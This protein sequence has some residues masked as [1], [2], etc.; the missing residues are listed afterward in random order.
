MDTPKDLPQAWS[1]ASG[2]ALTIA[3]LDPAMGLA[4]AR[5]LALAHR[6]I[7][8]LGLNAT[9]EFTTRATA[10]LGDGPRALFAT[11]EPLEATARFAK[12]I[13][14]INMMAPTARA[15]TARFER[16]D[17]R[18]L[19]DGLTGNQI[20]VATRVFAILDLLVE[21]DTYGRLDW[22]RRTEEMKDRSGSVLD[23]L[24]A[25]AVY[26]VVRDPD[27]RRFVERAR[28][29]RALDL[30][31]NMAIAAGIHDI[32][33]VTTLLADPNNANR[34]AQGLLLMASDKTNAA[35]AGVRRYNADGGSTAIASA[36]L[37]VDVAWSDSLRAAHD[38]A[39]A[40][41]PTT[42]PS[43]GTGPNAGLTGVVDVDNAA[44]GPIATIPVRVDGQL[45]GFVWALRNS[46]QRLNRR[47]LIV[48]ETVVG[49]IAQAVQ[50]ERA[51]ENLHR[52]AH[53]DP[54]TGLANRWQLQERLDRLFA[55]SVVD[56]AD[57]ALIMCD[58]DGL[59]HVNDSRGHAAGDEVLLNVA[60]TLRQVVED[61]PNS[62]VCRIGGDEFC[63]LVETAG[64]IQ[65]ESVASDATRLLTQLV[66]PGVGLS[67]GVAYGVHAEK[68]AD[69]LSAADQAQYLVKR[70]RPHRSNKDATDS[71][72]RRRRRDH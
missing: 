57:S 26:T 7:P 24:L 47:D 28:L 44:L 66:P 1:A 45:W 69:L 10:L 50:R 31:P 8:H 48:L 32:S 71:F 46:K 36:G 6:V 33:R 34:I 56:R 14:R 40:T 35:A 54:L 4:S 65:A 59:K 64:L 20:P 27:V 49:G 70:R 18:G 29:P 21:P 12:I 67:C 51:A 2:L 38:A 5:R 41:A 62:L 17:G 11:E 25:D 30:P 53:R 37:A 55:K 58:V 16:V 42:A 60:K 15:I 23:L 72:G 43:P 22:R 19:P 9:E 68:P 3:E 63:V 61:L 13:S 52:L 39:S